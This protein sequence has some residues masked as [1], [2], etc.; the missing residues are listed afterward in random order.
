MGLSAEESD[1]SKTLV[2]FISSCVNSR[3]C[4]YSLKLVSPDIPCL[5]EVMGLLYESMMYMFQCCG[6]ATQR[7]D[8][9]EWSFLSQKFTTFRN[10]YGLHDETDLIS[11]KILISDN[12]DVGKQK[13][14]ALYFIRLGIEDLKSIIFAGHHH[15]KRPRINGIV[16]YRSE[17]HDTLWRLGTLHQKIAANE[18]YTMFQKYLSSKES[19]ITML[20]RDT[21]S[22]IRKQEEVDGPPGL[23][24]SGGPS[25]LQQC[26]QNLTTTSTTNH[27][28]GEPTTPPPASP[29]PNG[30]PSL[31]LNRIRIYLLPLILSDDVM[32]QVDNFWRCNVEGKKS[33][34]RC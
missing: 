32:N 15:P 7:K 18:G 25:V 24:L 21:S 27:Q 16:S 22:T 11:S 34:Q 12:V 10:T 31:L 19:T 33:K 20:E 4:W 13:R 2:K 30:S 28:P 3:A 9:N 23:V 1:F 29:E 5:P 6:L 17:F 14:K 26:Q 8:G